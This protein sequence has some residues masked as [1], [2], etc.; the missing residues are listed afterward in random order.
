MRI[1]H[2]PQELEEHEEYRW[3]GLVYAYTPK[4]DGVCCS[5][6][7]LT[8]GGQ[9]CRQSRMSLPFHR[10]DDSGENDKFNK[11]LSDALVDLT[12]VFGVAFGRVVCLLHCPSTYQCPTSTE[13]TALSDFLEISILQ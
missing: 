12:L 7:L 4:D 6:P 1:V 8:S 3:F 2:L 5:R 10:A 13:T 9:V 11:Q